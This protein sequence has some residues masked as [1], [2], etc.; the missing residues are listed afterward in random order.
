M[1]RKPVPNVL[2]SSA[3]TNPPASPL[4]RREKLFL[5]ALTIVASGLRVMFLSEVHDNPFFNNPTSD[6]YYYDAQAQSIAGGDVVGKGVFFRAPGYPYWLG[7]IYAVFGHEYLAVRI[8]Q[9]VLGVVS[10][11]LL[12]L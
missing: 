6:A 5:V 7:V 1:L 8:I 9:H 3:G 10:L 4:H 2:L 12:Y 11:L